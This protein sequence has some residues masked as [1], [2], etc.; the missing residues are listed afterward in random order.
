M[1]SEAYPRPSGTSR[2][3]EPDLAGMITYIYGFFH[4]DP[5][6]STISKAESMMNSL[7]SVFFFLHGVG[8]RFRKLAARSTTDASIIFVSYPSVLSISMDST[9]SIGLWFF[10]ASHKVINFL[11]IELDCPSRIEEVL[12][13]EKRSC[14]RSAPLSLIGPMEEPRISAPPARC[15]EFLDC[16]AETVVLGM[17][18]TLQEIVVREVALLARM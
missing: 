9:W 6:S 13:Q 15:I 11:G 17:A 12:T 4:V 16:Q 1:S 8:T 7:E 2:G 10:T 18:L 5:S 3:E 14:S